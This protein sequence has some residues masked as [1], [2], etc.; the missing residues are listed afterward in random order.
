MRNDVGHVAYG[1]GGDL[2][3]RN[4]VGHAAYG[5]GGDLAVLIP[6]VAMNGDSSHGSKGSR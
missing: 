1:Y 2:E 4:D 5:C 6:S 3:E